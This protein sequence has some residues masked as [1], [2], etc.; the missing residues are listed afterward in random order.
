MADP[1]TT[2]CCSVRMSHH[3]MRR[4][5][6]LPQNYYF[7]IR[8]HLVAT[9]L[10]QQPPSPKHHSNPNPCHFWDWEQGVI[11]GSRPAPP[12]CT[13]ALAEPLWLSLRGGSP[14]ESWVCLLPHLQ[15]EGVPALAQYHL[16]RRKPDSDRNCLLR[17]LLS[18]FTD[19]TPLPVVYPQYLGF[20]VIQR[21]SG[22]FYHSVLDINFKLCT[23]DTSFLQ[24]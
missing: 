21:Y 4:I 14:G 9:E 10:R 12:C 3:V 13:G 16:K 18:G 6:P 1:W 15:M 23:I 8:R 17:L 24:C 19:T 2:A 5:Q 20:Q 11:P 22:L 7:I